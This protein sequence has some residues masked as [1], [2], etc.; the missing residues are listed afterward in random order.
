MRFYVFRT[1]AILVPILGA[2]AWYFADAN[3]PF[4]Q[5]HIPDGGVW[6]GLFLIALGITFASMGVTIAL[7]RL[8]SS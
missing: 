7:W 8:S 5:K 1:L 3:G 2:C 4:V 6:F